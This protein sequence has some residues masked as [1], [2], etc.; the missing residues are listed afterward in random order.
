M[1]GRF[2]AIVRD[3]AGGATRRAAFDTLAA[4]IDRV[5]TGTLSFRARGDK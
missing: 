2:P 4:V 3:A 5:A 1:G